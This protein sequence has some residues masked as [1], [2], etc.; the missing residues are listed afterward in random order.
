M[1]KSIAPLHDFKIKQ[2][3]SGLAQVL[4]LA[5]LI[6]LSGIQTGSSHGAEFQNQA[7]TEVRSSEED[8]RVTQDYRIGNI[9]AQM[10]FAQAGHYRDNQHFAKAL[11]ELTVDW[12]EVA[13]HY[14]LELI[15]EGE[16]A[17]IIARPLDSALH[18]F[19]GIAQV[20]DTQEPRLVETI[21]CRSGKPMGQI[22]PLEMQP[23]N[24]DYLELTCPDEF[25]RF[26]NHAGSAYIGAWNRAQQVYILENLQ[27][28]AQIENLGLN[29]S[30]ETPYHTFKVFLEER[31]EWLQVVHLALPK[32]DGIPTYIGITMTIETEEDFWTTTS[33]LCRATEP[34]NSGINIPTRTAITDPP[35]ECPVQFEQFSW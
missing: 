12:S 25:V 1:S 27:F 33:I 16:A 19:I 8:F 13:E 20:A 24:D 5:G 4:S 9:I 21:L 32:H 31:A 18:S 15:V 23:L 17:F 35:A 34:I 7:A 3:I 22:P 29:F 2:R 11:Q 6:I 14:Q 10:K 26:P 30:T 28:S